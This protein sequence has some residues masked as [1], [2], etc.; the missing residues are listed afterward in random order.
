MCIRSRR[1]ISL[2][3]WPGVQ[4]GLSMHMYPWFPSQHLQVNFQEL[5][6]HVFGDDLLNPKNR[7]ICIENYTNM[8]YHQ[9]Q[10]HSCPSVQLHEAFQGQFSD[11]TNHLRT[12]ISV[13]KQFY[14][15]AN[16]WR[17]TLGNRSKQATVNSST[18][19][20]T[21]QP[22]T[23]QLTLHQTRVHFIAT[24]PGDDWTISSYGAKGR[25][26]ALNSLHVLQ[27]LGVRMHRRSKM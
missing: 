23:F 16:W 6:I 12:K 17:M 14:L 20:I 5:G 13:I 27:P 25:F 2:G 19:S 11:T 24:T 7:K 8:T 21:T 9:Q 1:I 4:L 3:N 10:T 15:L 26:G 18:A 22:H